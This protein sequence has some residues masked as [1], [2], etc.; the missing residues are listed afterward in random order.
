M[1]KVFCDWCGAEATEC[2]VGGLFGRR[3]PLTANDDPCKLNILFQLEF[4]TDNKPEHVCIPC[5]HKIVTKA[6]NELLE[7]SRHTTPSSSP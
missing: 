4:V 3:I 5:F 1:I 7:E 6:V 2:N